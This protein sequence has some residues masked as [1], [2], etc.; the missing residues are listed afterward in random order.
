MQ[1]HP[2]LKR[3][4]K[5]I[6]TILLKNDIAGVIVLHSL[7]G[8]PETMGDGSMYTQGFT[9]FLFCINPSYSA[10]SIE[11]ERFKVKGKAIHYKSAEERDIKI[12]GTVNM[13]DHLSEW[14]GKLALSA[15]EMN[16]KLNEITEKI[17]TGNDEDGSF[18]S[19]TQQNN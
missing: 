18:S 4:I 3:A 17:K 1:Y 13:L 19:Y 9:E 16:D 6:Q 11:N 14:T 8:K 10:A 15:M 12:A 7:F 5:E 2:K